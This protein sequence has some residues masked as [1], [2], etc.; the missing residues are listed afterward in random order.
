[1][2]LLRPT[3]CG[4]SADDSD[5]D[6]LHH[7]R[8]TDTDSVRR[9]VQLH[10]RLLD[11]RRFEHIVDGAPADLVAAAVGAYANTDGGVAGVIEPD[12]RTMGS[13]P[14]AVLTAFDVLHEIGAPASD[15]M[16]DWLLAVANPDGGIPFCLPF[17][18]DAP[19]APWMVPSERSSLHMTAAVV[20]AALRLNAKHRWVDGASAFCRDRLGDLNA[21]NAYELKFAVE[22]LDAVGDV[23]RLEQVRDRIPASGRLPVEGGV[24]GE[25]M[26]LLDLAPT[27]D[28][29]ARR[30]FTDEQ[31][32]AALDELETGQRDDGGW[33]FDWL[34]WSPVAAHEWRARLTVDA[35][36]TL[37]ANGR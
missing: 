9:F 34:A 18:D 29:H 4:L 5:D 17:G 27:P 37:R 36:I 2:S 20:A 8:M 10:G 14:V 16:L 35:L 24:E 12:V 6:G 33:D 15:A 22:F 7:E 32:R 13:Q 11:R 19:H 30:L 25:A 28:R 3:R 21:L 31:V 26:T 1:M 23:E